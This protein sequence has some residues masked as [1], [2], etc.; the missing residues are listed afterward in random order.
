M[1]IDEPRTETWALPTVVPDGED[2]LLWIRSGVIAIEPVPD[3]PVLPGRFAS[4]GLVDAHI[5]VALSDIEDQGMEYA[6]AT[7]AASRDQGVLLVRDMGSPGRLTQRLPADPLLPRVIGCGEQLAVEAYFRGMTP[8]PRGRLVEAA[9]AEIEQ[10]IAWVKVLA[11]WLSPGLS[12]PIEEIKAMVEVA[13]GAGVRVAAHCLGDRIGEVVDAGVD[14]IEHGTSMD[15]PTLRRMADRGTAWVPTVGAWASTIA[16]A[17]VL[18]EDQDLDP[19]RRGRIEA[20]LATAYPFVDTLRRMIP[21]AVEL[22]VTI[23]PST[24]RGDTVADEVARFVSFG[25]DPEHAFRSATTIARQFL[26]APGL[27]ANAPA[28]VVTFD[29]DP[30]T[31]P[32]VLQEPVAI[33]LGGRRVR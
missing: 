1:S 17:E 15:E 18:L 24:D 8:V 9:R 25:V 6:L 32:T 3:A 19:E 2:R 11:D 7:L 13:H 22:G 23:L 5:H 27:E 29:R 4:P 33:V 20:Y 31:D 10:G 28:D 14:S 16:R 26:Q 12:Y 21:R 30:R